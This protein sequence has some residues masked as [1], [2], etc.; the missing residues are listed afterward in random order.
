MIF[1]VIMYRFSF[2]IQ[3]RGCSETLLSKKFPEHHI[4]VLDI[5]AKD[6]KKKQYLYYI[7]G[8]EKAFDKIHSYLQKS[9]AYKLA[10]EIE[11]TKDTIVLLVVLHQQ[12]YIQN[13]IQK[14][15]GFLIEHH[16]VSQGYEYWHIGITE[17]EIIGKMRSELKKVGKL[18][19]LYIGKV[20]FANTLL[21]PQQ[22]KIF[23]YAFK[24]GYYEIP[25]KTT[26]A[27]IAKVMNLTHATTG[28][29]LL[30]AENKIIHVMAKK[31]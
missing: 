16:T 2:R 9:R 3:H 20:E 12:G 8:Q 11:R 15:N 31:F 24:T 18:E 22:K 10:R 25:K 29:H 1:I 6:P 13:T 7:H 17:K 5:Q 28:E 4:T 19:T 23:N 26:I 30:K 21:S 14:Y 27:E